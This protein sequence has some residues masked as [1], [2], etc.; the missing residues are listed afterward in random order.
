MKLKYKKVL[1]K[2][3]SQLQKVGFRVPSF[4]A[5]SRAGAWQKIKKSANCSSAD[6]LRTCQPF[7]VL[8]RGTKEIEDGVGSVL[9]NSRKFLLLLSG[10]VAIKYHADP[11]DQ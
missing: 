7:M 9:N 8:K 11:S 6:R 10:Q 3:I 4:S 5:N 2:S 1:Y